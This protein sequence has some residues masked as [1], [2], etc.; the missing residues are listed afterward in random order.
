M[1]FKRNSLYLQTALA[2]ACCATG[3]AA[4]AH[5]AAVQTVFVIAMEN[6]NWTVN[7]VGY[8][9]SNLAIEGNPAAPFINS[10]VNGTSP[11]SSQV[12]Y[13]MDYNQPGSGEHPS[14]P[15]YVW[16]EAGTNFNPIATGATVS[17]NE[18]IIVGNTITN[19]NDPSVA[20]N[21]I[22][23]NVPHLTG[24]MNAKGVTWNNYQEDYQFLNTTTPL[25]GS[26]TQS[27]SGTSTTITNPYYNTNQYNYAV[28]HNPMA[29]FTDTATQNTMTF[30]K[31]R[32]DL[33]ADTVTVSHPT[34]TNNFGQYNWITPNQFNDM[35]SGLSTA[36]SYA[37]QTF[38]AGTD[39]NAVAVGDNFLATI[40]PEIMATSA[41]KNNGAIVIWT[42]ETEGGDTSAYTTPEIVLSPLAHPNV[43]GLP[44]G[45]TVTMNH[46]SDI[47]TMEEIFGLPLLP[48]NA[49]PASET[50]QGVTGQYATV[51]GSNDLSDLFAPGV[52]PAAAPVPEPASLAVLTLGAL[53]L[54]ARRKRA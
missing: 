37:G 51:Q 31:L 21:N 29:F 44:Y 20:S 9:G 6:H 48:N 27:K 52:I 4:A 10:L 47:K 26:S 17:T 50:F 15:N 11:F 12:S 30:D 22:F 46:S 38:L 18:G 53:G 19:D 40:I 34:A 41:Y 36:F 2:A 33:S 54:L 39:Q 45:S 42:D 13:A 43:G 16:A 32:S 25:G 5:A 7:G 49:I 8:N 14:E 24:Q 3:M 35:H 23:S 28:K 1:K